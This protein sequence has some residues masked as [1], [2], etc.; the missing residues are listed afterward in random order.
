[1]SMDFEAVNDEAPETPQADVPSARMLSWA[2]NSASYRLAKQMLTERQ[3]RDAITRK[4]RQKFEEISDRQVSALADF[5]VSFGYDV[6]ALNDTTYAEVAT[7]QGERSGRSRRAIAQ[8]LSMKGVAAETTK[9]AVAEVDDLKAAVILARKRAF[10]PF[11]RVELDEK[12]RGKELSAFARGGFGFD[13]GRRVCE[14]S[15][16]EADEILSGG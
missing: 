4:A 6:G 11:R 13:I 2:R 9:A 16:Q 8:K 5:A 10:G 1:M 14:M 3:L 7:R 12:R 15:A